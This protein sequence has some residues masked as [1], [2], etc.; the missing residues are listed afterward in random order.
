MSTNVYVLRCADGK[1]YVGKAVDIQKRFQQH[2]NGSGSAWTNKYKPIAIEKTYR[3]VS[4]FDEDK[5]TKET[6]ANYGINNV[7][8]G[9]YSSIK[10]S[11]N[12]KETLQKE[13]RGAQDRCLICGDIT[14]FAKN[15]NNKEGEKNNVGEDFD[16]HE[17][18]GDDEEEEDDDEDEDDEEEDEDEDEDEDDDE[19]EDEDEE[20]DEDEDD[21]HYYSD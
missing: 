5:I 10:L 11:D 6:M 21:G 18:E 8:G 16:N 1:R 2:R 20:E 13:I 12:Q 19:D 3:N 17:E 9:T 14:H 4:A 7:R 15:C